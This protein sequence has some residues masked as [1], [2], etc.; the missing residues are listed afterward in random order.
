[1]AETCAQ[2]KGGETLKIFLKMHAKNRF[3][4]VQP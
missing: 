1:M 2:T 3:S 4:S